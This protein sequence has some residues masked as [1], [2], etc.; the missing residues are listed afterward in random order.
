MLTHWA[1]SRIW[2]T[3]VVSI[4]I[5]VV[6]LSVDLYQQSH[7]NIHVMM[8]IGNLKGIPW[9]NNLGMFSFAFFFKLNAFEP[10]ANLF[11]K[12]LK[13]YA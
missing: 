12:Q 8:C 1:I 4:Q 6:R 11:M 5:G 9:N 13:M 10:N 3:G 2:A 7:N